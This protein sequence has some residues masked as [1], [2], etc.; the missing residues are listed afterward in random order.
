MTG[1]FDFLLWATLLPLIVALVIDIR[2][3][4]DDTDASDDE[5]DPHPH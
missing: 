3:R 4:A 5:A 1:A 2:G